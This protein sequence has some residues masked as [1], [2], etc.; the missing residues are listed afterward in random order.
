[1]LESRLKNGGGRVKVSLCISLKYMGSGGVAA[2][3][4]NIGTRWKWVGSAL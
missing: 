3:I 2:L 4:C 1:M